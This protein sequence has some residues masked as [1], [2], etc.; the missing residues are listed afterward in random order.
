MGLGDWWDRHGVPR[1]IK[2]ACGAPAIMKLRSQI[3]PLASGTVFELGCGGGINQQFYRADA[4]T[5]YAGIDPNGKLLDY[6]RAEA[7][8]KGWAADIRHGFGEDIPFADNSFD[9]V[10][11]TYTLCSVQVQARVVQEMRRIL[12]PGGKL[13]FL[14]HG[15]A[16]DADVLRWQERIEP[17]WKPVAGG[18]HL[19]RPITEAVRAGGFAIEPMGARYLP[20]TP[21]PVGWN[22]WG[23][24]IKSSA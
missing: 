10:V 12:K 19:T 20:K 8:A 22:E 24:G 1:V 13:L 3:V 17:W 16:P 21:R 11:C 15:R 14:E 7:E 9:T 4:I 18:C 5:R 6:A 2:I 23:V